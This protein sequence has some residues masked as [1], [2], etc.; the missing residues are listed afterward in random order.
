MNT[1]SASPLERLVRSREQMRLALKAPPGAAPAAGPPWASALGSGPLAAGTAV[2]MWVVS[3]RPMVRRH[4]W[5]WALGSMAV[6]ATLAR[7]RP[8]R[9]LFSSA[10]LAAVLPQLASRL[11][12]SWPTQTSTAP[13]KNA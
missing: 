7:V 10:V 13:S 9:W 4:P 8:W 2:A 3:L 11:M 5:A 6:G 1:E 12:S